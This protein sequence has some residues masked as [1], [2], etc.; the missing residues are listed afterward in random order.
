MSKFQIKFYRGDYFQRQ[1]AANRDKAICYVEH[2]FNGGSATANYCL[3]NVA[4]NASWKSKKFAQSY[5]DKISARLEVKKAE[6]D[7][8]DNGVSV[9]GY[10]RRGNKNIYFTA[11]PAILLEPLFATNPVHAN[12]IKTESGVLALAQCLADSIEEQFPNGGI[13]AFSVGH[14]YKTSNPADRGVSLFGGGTE[15][16][17]C[18]KVLLKAKEL[19]EK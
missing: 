5:V 12:L 10:K 13:V 1:R 14:K 7:F 9:G 6:N 2:H 16:D 11:C 4:T 18:E 8:A 15:A 17:Y 19:L 3:V